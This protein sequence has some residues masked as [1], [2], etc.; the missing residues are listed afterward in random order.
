M[1]LFVE[2][3]MHVQTDRQTT[4]HNAYWG[5]CLEG[6]IIHH[7]TI[8]LKVPNALNLQPSLARAHISAAPSGTPGRVCPAEFSSDGPV[9]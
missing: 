7:I 6:P 5:H 3:G 2:L 4:T 1:T 8:L 9:L